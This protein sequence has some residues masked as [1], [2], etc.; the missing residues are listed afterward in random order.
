MYSNSSPI[1]KDEQFKLIS[2]SCF[3]KDCWRRPSPKGAGSLRFWKK[4]SF[5]APT[6][7]QLELILL[8]LALFHLLLVRLA[9]AF[10]A[11]EGRSKL[12]TTPT[13]MLP[14]PLLAG[15]PAVVY[16]CMARQWLLDN[17]RGEEE[18]SSI[19]IC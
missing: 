17:W 10:N 18:P 9:S 12:Q 13:P 5:P 16:Q 7:S 6:N 8:L 14:C 2:K 3:I 11:Q 15:G 4:A 19:G 1:K